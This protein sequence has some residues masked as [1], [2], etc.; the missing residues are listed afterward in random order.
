[1]D[2]RHRRQRCRLRQAGNA[3]DDQQGKEATA[4]G[5]DMVSTVPAS[6]TFFFAFQTVGAIVSIAERPIYA[7]AP[8]EI[9]LARPDSRPRAGANPEQLLP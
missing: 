4:G 1:M 3:M 6:F 8:F 2:E 7:A 5:D 9:W